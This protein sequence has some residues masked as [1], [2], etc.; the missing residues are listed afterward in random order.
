[1][2]S[3]VVAIDVFF[4]ED[5]VKTYYAADMERDG[6]TMLTPY[7]SQACIFQHCEQAALIAHALNVVNGESNWKVLTL[8]VVAK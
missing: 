7:L 1:M 4:D 5:D 3:F 8:E 2:N 6:T